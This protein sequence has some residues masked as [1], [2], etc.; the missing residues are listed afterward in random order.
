MFL[1]SPVESVLER[2]RRANIARNQRTLAEMGLNTK[3]EEESGEEKEE[4]GDGAGQ[5]VTPPNRR[6]REAQTSTPENTVGKRRKTSRRG[7]PDD[8]E[9][10][11]TT[12]SRIDFGDDSEDGDYTEEVAL[13][14]PYGQELLQV[15]SLSL[16]LALCT[17]T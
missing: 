10:A 12:R 6:K 16:S 15:S 8:E 13:G 2:T 4:G 9:H 17:Y 5:F 11:E 3:E 7:T 14:W 1:F